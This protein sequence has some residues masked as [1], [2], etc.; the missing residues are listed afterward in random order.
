VLAQRDI[1]A[2][3]VRAKDMAQC[4]V[5]THGKW[6]AGFYVSNAIFRIDAV[7]HRALKIATSESK[8]TMKVLILRAKELYKTRTQGQLWERSAL[9]QVNC[10]VNRLKHTEG[11]IIRHRDVGLSEAIQATEELLAFIEAAK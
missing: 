8:A 11:G 1:E 3:L 4:R 2:V 10:E 9:G 6:T 5:R 7:C